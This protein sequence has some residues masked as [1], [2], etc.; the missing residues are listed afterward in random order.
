MAPDERA[1]EFCK[2]AFGPFGVDIEPYTKIVAELIQ[3]AVDEEAERLQT[4]RASMKH[5]AQT[6]MDV[7]LRA[8]VDRLRAIIWNASVVFDFYDMPEY[9][10][11]YRKRISGNVQ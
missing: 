2:T 1:R 4:L 5:A 8:E 10:T 7:A 11:H 3:G 9:A 6:A